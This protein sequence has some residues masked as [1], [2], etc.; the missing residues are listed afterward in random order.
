MDINLP[1]GRRIYRLDEMGSDDEMLD[2]YLHGEQYYILDRSPL[3]GGEV[4]P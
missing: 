3:P 2:W 4:E 1:D